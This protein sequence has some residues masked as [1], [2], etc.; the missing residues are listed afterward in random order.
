MPAH[1]RTPAE[2][3]AKQTID[4]ELG[5]QDVVNVDKDWYLPQIVEA[6]AAVK[7]LLASAQAQPMDVDPPTEEQSYQMFDA[8]DVLGLDQGPSSPVTPREDQL[9]DP[10]GGFSRA[11]G[12]RRPPAGLSSRKITGRA[13]EEKY[14]FKPG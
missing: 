4:E 6:A 2:L 8:S 1:Y 14:N 11:L 7:D 5:A 13:T 12:D 10:P 3:E 9:L